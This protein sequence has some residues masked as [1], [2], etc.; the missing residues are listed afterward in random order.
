MWSASTFRAGEED[1]GECSLQTQLPLLTAN[2]GHHECAAAA[3][4]EQ[5]AQNRVHL[6][7]FGRKPRRASREDPGVR[8]L[9]VLHP[10]REGS[11]LRQLPPAISVVDKHADDLETGHA[12]VQRNNS[13]ELLHRVVCAGAAE[14]VKLQRIR[15]EGIAKDPKDKLQLVLQAV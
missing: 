1:K 10:V 14:R 12:A 8:G 2:G 3:E 6:T 4:G 15:A 11:E 13:H 5:A 7:L 9:D